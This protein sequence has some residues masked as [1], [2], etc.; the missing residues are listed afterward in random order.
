MAPKS[1]IPTPAIRQP[2]SLPPEGNMP[3][4]FASFF[5]D[6]ENEKSAAPGKV[7]DSLPTTNN[8][9]TANASIAPHTSPPISHSPATITMSSSTASAQQDPDTGAWSMLS[10]LNVTSPGTNPSQSLSQAFMQDPETGAWPVEIQEHGAPADVAT[11][12]AI[13]DTFEGVSITSEDESAS[14]ED[15]RLQ[16]ARARLEEM[17]QNMHSS[18]FQEDLETAEPNASNWYDESHADFADMS[19]EILSPV[20]LSS[21]SANMSGDVEPSYSGFNPLNGTRGSPPAS[22]QHADQ[23]SSSDDDDYGDGPMPKVRLV[24][25]EEETATSKAND[26]DN[27]YGSKQS[28]TSSPSKLEILLRR[29]LDEGTSAE[30]E[31]QSSARAFSP[32]QLSSPSALLEDSTSPS[33]SAMKD[34]PSSIPSGQEVTSVTSPA[35]P[36]SP[37][38]YMTSPTRLTWGMLSSP[39]A[40]KDIPPISVNKDKSFTTVLH[41]SQSPTHLPPVPVEDDNTPSPTT[42]ESSDTLADDSPSLENMRYVSPSDYGPSF[43]NIPVV[44][45]LGDDGLTWTFSPVNENDGEEREKLE[46]I[47][48]VGEVDGS[49]A[50]ATSG[51][52]NDP[53]ASTKPLFGPL[54]GTQPTGTSNL[55]S[56]DQSS[57]HGPFRVQKTSI[58]VG[59]EDEVYADIL[60]KIHHLAEGTVQMRL[61]MLMEAGP[62]L[63]IEN[64][65]YNP[66]STTVYDPKD[67]DFSKVLPLLHQLAQ[68]IQKPLV[69]ALSLVSGKLRLLIGAADVVYEEEN[70]L[71]APWSLGNGSLFGRGPEEPAVVGPS[72]C[73][74]A[75]DVVIQIRRLAREL[76]EPVIAVRY[77]TETN[78]DWR[79]EPALFINSLKDASWK[80]IV[81][82]PQDGSFEKLLP[83]IFQFQET[84]QKHLMAHYCTDENLE[85]PHLMI[86]AAEDPK[87]TYP[88][89]ARLFAEPYRC[90][91]HPNPDSFRPVFKDKDF[92]A[93]QALTNTIEKSTTTPDA[94]RM[95]LAHPALTLLDLQTAF[96]YAFDLLQAANVEKRRL[97]KLRDKSD[98]VGEADGPSSRRSSEPPSLEELFSLSAKDCRLG[99]MDFVEARVQVFEEIEGLLAA[100]RVEVME[101]RK[102]AEGKKFAELVEDAVFTVIM[103]ALL[104]ALYAFLRGT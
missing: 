78:E 71:F 53:M 48:P 52:Q 12:T 58:A 74:N 10:E 66:Y 54:F 62:M 30:D 14:S 16:A 28:D 89:G 13:A 21:Q 79:F 94:L 39:P 56:E 60:S 1:K 29:P 104:A 76:G 6:M 88:N 103:L 38:K 2:T 45:V 51:V 27:S 67:G 18:P 85:H 102:K 82:D 43:D 73:G 65:D 32:H 72:N 7:A 75:N 80:P 49:D 3:S 36:S 4:R 96:R 90:P 41:P 70:H 86:L 93:P 100:K 81:Y 26:S 84:V 95:C 91:E 97:C 99:I 19:D 101:K 77:R 68:K 83:V 8:D 33:L 42:I 11:P 34:S 9:K 59:P 47:M 87:S 44:P 61:G 46:K 23:E 25:G 40:Q 92:N 50:P 20:K 37:P 22:Q 98:E 57:F 5:K 64:V 55:F 69:G 63:L 24:E 15:A 35:I 31:E 17:I